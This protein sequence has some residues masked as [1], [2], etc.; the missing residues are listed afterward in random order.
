MFNKEKEIADL[1]RQTLH[2]H[3]WNHISDMDD[4]KSVFRS[5]D[6]SHIRKKAYKKYIVSLRRLVGSAIASSFIR[7]EYENK[8]E[9]AIKELIESLDQEQ[10][11]LANIEKQTGRLKRNQN[12]FFH[13]EGRENRKKGN[14]LSSVEV[15]QL[16]SALFDIVSFTMKENGL[17]HIQPFEKESIFSLI[18]SAQT[19]LKKDTSFSKFVDVMVEIQ[20]KERS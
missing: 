4:A 11:F 17:S 16:L 6:K 18:C 9:Q 15:K 10:P 14:N 7:S 3:A 20:A 8:I 1:Q 13:D 5:I 12:S 19:E 2:V